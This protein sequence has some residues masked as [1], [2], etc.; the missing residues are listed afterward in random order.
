MAVGGLMSD[1]TAIDISV[2][3]AQQRLDGVTMHGN[4]RFNVPYISEI[5][6]N[7]W[8]GGVANGLKLGGTIKH[9]V[10]LYPWE[11]Y[12]T[13]QLNSFLCVAMFDSLDQGFEQVLDIAS[14]VNSCRRQGPVLVHCQAGLN[15]SSLVVGAAL[16]MADEM[17]GPEAVAH[18]R[19]KRSP[20]C[21]CNPAFEKWLTGLEF[22]SHPE[23]NACRAPGPG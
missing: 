1:P 19:D 17:T 12:S 6:S 4:K 10:S 14:W 18:I 2:D 13:G 11:S 20:A 22:E 23:W 9:L 21:L 16:V 7:L 5:A 8:Q 15:R 3:P